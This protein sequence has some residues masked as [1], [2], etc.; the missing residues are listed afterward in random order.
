MKLL[1]LPLML[2]LVLTAST[3][4]MAQVTTATITGSITDQGGDPLIG[5][6]IVALNTATGTQ[7]GTTTNV[8]GRFTL[9]NL[10]V[11]GPYE[12]TASYVGYNDEKQEG[13][14]LALGQTARLDFELASGVEL[15][16]VVVTGAVDPN[17]NRDRTGVAT[18]V[19][20]TELTRLPTITRSASDYTRLTPASD[21]NSFAGRNDQFN[22]F[23]LDG[24]IFNNP[25]GL[26]AATPGGQT[27]AQPIS[28]DAIDQIQV[29]IAPY[30]VTQAGFTGAAV[31]AVTKSG[32]NEF[33][34]TV[35]GF[36]RNQDLTGS[37]VAGDD[38]F[39]PELSQLQAGFSLGGPIIK[40]KLFFFVNAEIE[41]RSDL[42][43]NFVAARPGL[44]GE[45]VS[46]VEAADL[47]AISDALFD[48]YGYETGP[49]EN[50]LF[51]QNN[52]KGIFK[53]DWNIGQ[54]QTL[55]A[56]YNFLDATKEKPAHPFA[57]GRRGPDATTLQFRNSGYAIN[58]IIHSAIVEHR[59]L[60]SDKISNK[61]QL[62]Y[63]AFRDSR[64]PFSTPFPSILIQRDGINYIVAGHEPFS[65]NNNLDQDVYQV[66]N[67]LNV[68]LNKHTLTIGASLE[69]F[70]FDNSF[71]L[72]FYDGAF[73]PFLPGAQSPSAF[74]DSIQA[75][76][77]DGAV[78]AA[79]A[80][81]DAL[82]GP[83]E[84]Y[85]GTGW[86]LAETNVGQFAFY[87][88]DEIDVSDQFKLTL[89]VRMDMPLY[90]DTEEKIKENL[91]RQCCYDPSIEYFDTDG[92]SVFFDHTVLPDNSPLISPRVG[93]NYDISGTQSTILRGGSGLFTGRFPFVWLGNQV[94]NPNF[95]FYTI[96][97]PTFQF[98]QVWRSNLGIDRKA[99]GWTISADLV[100]TK[101]INAMM[102]R[103]YGLK[104]PTGSLSGVDNRPIYTFDDRA[105]VFGGPTNAYV[106][107]NTDE[108]Y[109]FNASLQIR[110]NWNNG[111]FTSLGYNFLDAQD[112][113]SI[114]AEI[115]SDAY[116]RNPA[117]NHVNQ[118]R[119]TP[120]L[121]GNR[122]R[123]V[124][125]AHKRFTYGDWA[126]TVAAFFEYA[127]GGRFSYT[128][129][130]DINGDGSV[131]NDLIYIPTTSELQQMAFTG[132]AA[133][134]DAQRQALEDFIQQD[135]YLSGNRGGYAEKYDILSPWYS[136][137]D[138]RV[139]Q[140]YILPNQNVV[141]VSLDM[142][143]IGNFV[144]SNWGVRQF[145]TNTQPIGVSVAD[146]IPTYSFDTNLT[147][148]FTN[149]FSLGSR[150]QLQV[151][152]RYIF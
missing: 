114:E 87:V 142:L 138:V 67:N 113:S 70:E 133:A 56:T 54:N 115:S 22:N 76:A 49:Y 72:G 20:S 63:S 38:I 57:L 41:D 128:Y 112:A 94:A 68:F 78:A 3:G 36:T 52:T 129:S 17:V 32:T 73:G 125:T 75:G 15:D 35:F 127:Q 83:G 144:S 134:Q 37:K 16:A 39:V 58:N 12:L 7:Y 124:G 40:N 44:G 152:L 13:I 1:R 123:F 102:V 143:N 33:K 29:N 79:Q 93:F 140:D 23:S 100:Y 34:G 80:T 117:I 145:P 4:L 89:G 50:F 11:G 60:F 25:F 48:R 30:D 86:S 92:N 65:V 151:G 97:E 104:P 109:S 47:E 85:D 121:Y 81:F 77:L 90:F 96:T 130:G 66:T 14:F 108:G 82:N 116:E 19:G 135:E 137:W 91:A 98:P 51:N 53:L 74:V 126:T 111:W 45:Q 132:D 62:G 84:G 131:L 6:T 2:V 147:E 118:A 27:D 119:L 26:D 64:D 88:Q 101:D 105:T 46:R 107:T 110:K 42:G 31:N 28:L 146:G 5:A 21:G 120:S 95:F 136:R 8:D 55:T 43:S 139:L 103:N 61:L 148:T 71:N 150:W 59:A 24:S 18:L 69:R 122:H 149:D 10:R 9:P 141:Q 106:F 99:N